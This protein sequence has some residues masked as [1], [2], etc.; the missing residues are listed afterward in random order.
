VSMRSVTSSEEGE[1]SEYTTSQRSTLDS[2]YERGQRLSA[3]PSE[4]KETLD[5][6]V[7]RRPTE[8]AGSDSDITITSLRP[9]ETEP[10]I[11]N[12]QF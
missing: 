3:G 4:D 1:A 7:K 8:A 9:G 11:P 6:A 10:V 5:A 12:E 2:N